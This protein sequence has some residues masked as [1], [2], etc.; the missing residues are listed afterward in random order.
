MWDNRNKEIKIPQNYR[1][2]TVGGIGKR[3]TEE[4]NQHFRYQ[5]ISAIV[6]VIVSVFVLLDLH[7]VF[8]YKEKMD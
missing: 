2:E 4:G 6:A 7:I 8:I 5:I 1:Q 3:R